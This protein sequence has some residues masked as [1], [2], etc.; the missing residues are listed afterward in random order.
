MTL[1]ASPHT[2]HTRAHAVRM[3]TDAV[4]HRR[5]KERHNAPYFARVAGAL[6][7]S[8][9]MCAPA[10]WAQNAAPAT[11]GAATAVAPGRVTGEVKA[12]DE[13]STSEPAAD[14]A[15]Q[16]L[17]DKCVQ[18]HGDSMWRDIRQDQR[19]WTAAL[20]R[21]VGRG[22]IWSEGEINTLAQYLATHFG[23]SANSSAK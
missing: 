2:P 18:C 15:R 9:V 8:I 23:P 7:L 16:L 14:P 17:A 10:A 11:T 4:P 6:V 3:A 20:Y 5:R 1:A 21:M 13:S 22:A 19:G 12:T